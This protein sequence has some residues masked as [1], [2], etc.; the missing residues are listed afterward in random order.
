[1]DLRTGRGADVGENTPNAPTNCAVRQA[2]VGR[3]RCQSRRAALLDSFEHRIAV[4]DEA[5]DEWNAL[6]ARGVPAELRTARKTATAMRSEAVSSLR[7]YREDDSALQIQLDEIMEGD[8]DPDLIAD[9]KSL[10][11]LVDEHW[12]T[13]E[14]RAQLPKEKGA[15]FLAQAE[16]LEAA[17]LGSES[18]PEAREALERRDKAFF[19]LSD[20]EQELRACGRH[21]FRDKPAVAEL[22]ADALATP[23]N[24]RRKGE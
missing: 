16:A 21:A 5:Q 20:A 8:G 9:M 18:T 4:L 6:R 3:C 1:M 13:I 11:P 24:G 23:R 7:H 14:A 12:S 22:F 19:F 17:R 10:A 15:A 2:L